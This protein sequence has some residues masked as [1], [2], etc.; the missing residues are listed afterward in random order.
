MTRPAEPLPASQPTQ[1]PGSLAGLLR[2][3]RHIVVL[4]LRLRD[5]ALSRS[6][7]A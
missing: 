7:I 4:D 5:R 6:E 1:S 2:E 3:A